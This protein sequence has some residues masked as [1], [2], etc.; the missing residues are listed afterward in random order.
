MNT[1]LC[2]KRSE[3]C[4]VN[5]TVLPLVVVIFKF[6]VNPFRLFKVLSL[7]TYA[8]TFVKSHVKLF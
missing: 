4:R 3:L 2:N 8:Y 1:F 6:G 7:S 5:V